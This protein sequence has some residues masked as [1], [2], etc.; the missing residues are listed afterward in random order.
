MEQIV[1]GSFEPPK[2]LNYYSKVAEMAF[3]EVE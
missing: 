1:K 3:K 2:P